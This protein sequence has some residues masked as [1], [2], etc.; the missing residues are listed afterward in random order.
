MGQRGLA[1]LVQAGVRRNNVP[2][3]MI[4]ELANDQVE[5]EASKQQASQR[6]E[7]LTRRLL[8]KMQKEN[9]ALDGDYN[10]YL[11]QNEEAQRLHMSLV[12]EL[13]V[14]PV[15]AAYALFATDF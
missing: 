6:V 1:P 3:E 7:Q 14:K 5:Q 13:N 10:D 11:L 2:Y 15:I 4:D 12:D 8:R 9:K